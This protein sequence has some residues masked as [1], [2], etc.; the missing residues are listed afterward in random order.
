MTLVRCVVDAN[1]CVKLFVPEENSDRAINLFA[2]PKIARQA[3]DLLFIECANVLW[4]KVRK[5]NYLAGDAV[6]DLQDLRATDTV[7]TPTADLVVRAFELANEFDIS[8]YDACYV[9]LAESLGVP[10]VTADE[11]LAAKLAGTAHQV[12]TL[13]MV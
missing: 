12:V 11:R 7:V 9:A 3:P 8:A 2:N 5:G 10:L 6:N 4:T 1:V 13:A